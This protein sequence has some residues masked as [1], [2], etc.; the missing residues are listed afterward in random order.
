MIRLR[1][2]GG[3]LCV[4]P[5]QVLLHA[6]QVCAQATHLCIGLCNYGGMT[7]KSE[8]DNRLYLL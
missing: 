7:V 4:R 2:H 8:S 5:L 3:K 6:L 1:L